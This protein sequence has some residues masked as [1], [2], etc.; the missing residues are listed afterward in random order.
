[1][2][3][4]IQI[5]TLQKQLTAA[6]QNNT[7]N[8]ANIKAQIDEL[9]LQITSLA[10][11]QANNALGGAGSQLGPNRKY[12]EYDV[13]NGNVYKTLITNGTTKDAAGNLDLLTEE[14]AQRLTRMKKDLLFQPSFFSGDKVDFLERMEFMSK[15]TRPARNNSNKGFSFTFPPVC[16]LHLGSWFNHDIIINNVAYDYADAPW[17]IDGTGGRVQPMWALVTLSFNIVGTYGGLGNQDVPLSTD[18]GGFYQTKIR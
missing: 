15:L 12:S 1:K 11:E 4:Q 6:I 14:T 3:K 16:H 7:G 17:T 9:N 10:E 5:A 8:A 2:N 18:I 13:I